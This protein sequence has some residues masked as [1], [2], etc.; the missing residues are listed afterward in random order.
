MSVLSLGA[1]TF[2]SGMPPVTTVD[3]Q[4]RARDGRPRARRGREPDRHRRRVRVRAVGGDPRAL[5]AG[6]GRRRDDVLVATK[7]GFGSHDAGAL[8]YDNVVAACEASLGRLGLDHID[9]YQLHRPDRTTPIEETLRALDDLVARGLVRAVGTSNFRAWETSAAVARQRA[10]GRPAFTATQLYYSLVAREAEHELIP[11][12]RADDLGVIVWSPLSSGF[13]TGR[14]RATGD[15]SRRGSAHDVHVPARR[16]RAGGAGPGRAGRGRRRPRRVDGA[17]GAGVGAGAAGDHVGHRRRQ[18]P[19]AARRQPRRRRPRAH[20]R[21]SSPPSTRPP[22]WRRSTRRGGIPPWA[23]PAPPTSFTDRGAADVSEWTD[24]DQRQADAAAQYEHIMTTPAPPAIG[25]YIDAGVIG[26]V[27]G[28]MWR[29]G[30]LTPRDRRWVTLACV[31]AADAPVPME[32]HTYAALEQR[33]RH[34][35]GDRRVPAV[36]RDPDGLA[37]GLGDEPRRSSPPW[38]RSPRSGARRCSS[39]GSCR[40]PTRSTTTFAARAARPRT[41]RC[42]A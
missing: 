34:Q 10:L 28:E 23:S 5:R 12:C 38:R 13:L 2:G 41:R 11:E 14:Y 36:L 24:R 6:A 20:R 25:A 35:R 19:R 33:R 32:T 7:C 18:Q 8:S 39:R 40:G 3:E 21:R 27:F 26:F 42:T 1:M 31:G 30:V 17:G 4:R 22:R 29:R 16:S 9:L 15:G 37:Q